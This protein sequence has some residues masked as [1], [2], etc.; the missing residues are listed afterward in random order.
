MED[1]LI[2]SYRGSYG[3]S[4]ELENDLMDTFDTLL[5]P[6][7]TSHPLSIMRSAALHRDDP[8]NMKSVQFLLHKIASLSTIEL[9]GRGI[10]FFNRWQLRS[11]LTFLITRDAYKSSLCRIHLFEPTLGIPSYDTYRNHS[12][13]TLTAY[14]DMLKKAGDIFHFSNLD[15]VVEIEQLVYRYLSPD[16]A[17]EDPATSHFTYTLDSF[18]KEYPSIPL[19]CMLEAWGC[20]STVIH[21][22]TFVI[23]NQRYIAAFDRMCK[24]FDIEAFHIW[25]QAYALITLMPYLPDP[26]HHIQFEF[27]GKILQGK[28][29]EP[30]LS[31]FS[32]AILQKFMPQS[33]GKI[34]YEHEPNAKKI[35]KESTE[36]VHRLKQAAIHRFNAV[37]WLLPETKAMG[38]KKIQH[39]HMQIGYPRTWRDPTRRLSLKPRTLVENII[40]LGEADT[41]QSI[42]ELGYTCS[43]DDGVWDDGIYIVNAFYY[44]DQNKM[45]IPLGILQPPFFDR[46]Q[47]I[48]WNYGG[49]GCAIAHEIT[50]GFDDGGRLYDETGSWKNWWSHQDELHYHKQTDKLV[51]LFDN[52]H[53][54]GGKINGTLTLDENLADLGGMA[55]SLQA[56][57]EEIKDSDKRIPY[58]RD[59]FMAYAISWRFK[60]RVKKAQQALEIDRHAPA[61]FRVNLI[62]SQFD[63]FY[64]AFD[65][66]EDSPMWTAPESRLRLW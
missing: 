40:Q 59:F 46:K 52:R 7:S 32:I 64:E 29:T 36:L 65:I 63:E 4:E 19:T 58:L 21:S 9:V 18:T 26:I 22:A 44:A 33:L 8:S 51:K 50:H 38:V 35:K 16:G 3:V 37:E 55:I 1:T 66:P 11:P 53:Y 28:T 48:G 13:K 31:E 30:P 5:R 14:R 20:V 47:S 41:K 34:L 56:L 43:K 62:V 2:P 60:D 27:Y 54:K 25:L 24:T 15:D 17:L 45:V 61:P 57:H 49:I 10:G 23:T 6:L 39:M 12:N 42:S